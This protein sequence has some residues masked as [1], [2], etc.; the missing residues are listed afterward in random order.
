MGLR[1]KEGSF[2]K[3]RPVSRA[4][5]D[6]SL[7]TRRQLLHVRF[8]RGHAITGVGEEDGYFFFN[9]IF[10]YV[11]GCVCSVPMEARRGCWTLLELELRAIMSCPMWVLETEVRS[12]E[13][14]R[15]SYLRSHLSSPRHLIHVKQREKRNKR[16]KEGLREAQT[17][18]TN[19]SLDTHAGT[20][21]PGPATLAETSFLPVSHRHDSY[22]E[23]SLLEHPL[24][25]ICLLSPG[26]K[27]HLVC[28]PRVLFLKEEEKLT[29]SVHNGDRS[30]CKDETWSSE[31]SGNGGQTGR[32]A[33]WQEWGGGV[34]W[35]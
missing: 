28:I 6:S 20:M 33:C 26:D 17:S 14:G 29:L 24:S 7:K 13:G 19:T 2:S 23:Q 5:G 21:W 22:P 1:W 25:R 32:G 34:A 9:F 16:W 31:L 11:Y 4:P 8:K 3:H 27:T 18:I 30:H 35:A 15:H 10:I 12:T